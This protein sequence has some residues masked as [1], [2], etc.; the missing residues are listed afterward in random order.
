MRD[1]S[2]KQFE[3]AMKRNGWRTHGFM[4]YWDRNGHGISRLNY[5]S[6]REALAAFIKQGEKHDHE[7]AKAEAAQDTLHGRSL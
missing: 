4:G 2:K 3:T 1:M 6:N 5:G 7:R